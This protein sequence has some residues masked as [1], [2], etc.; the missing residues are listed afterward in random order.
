MVC[1]IWFESFE[2]LSV[3]ERV[4]IAGFD[5]RSDEFISYLFEGFQPYPY[6]AH[7]S[8]K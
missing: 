2:N 6:P 1:W 4:P 3:A 5:K 8:K 7:F